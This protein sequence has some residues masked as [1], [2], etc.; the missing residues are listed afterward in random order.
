MERVLKK[1]T[2]MFEEEL[3]EISHLIERSIDSDIS[4]RM[5]SSRIIKA[6]G[7]RLRPILILAYATLLGSPMASRKSEKAILL[8]SAVELIHT[9]TLL[10]D[11]VIDECCVRRGVATANILWGNKYSILV[12][13]YLFSQSF[14]LMV[15]ARS[16][17]SL[18]ILAHTSSVISK[19]ELEQLEMIRN[20]EIPLMSRYLKTAKEKTAELFAAACSVGAILGAKGSGL[21][22][23]ETKIALSAARC[24]G[25]NFGKIFQIVDDFLDYF[26]DESL[27]GKDIRQDLKSRKV[28][29]PL[30]LAYRYADKFEKMGLMESFFGEDDVD[31]LTEIVHSLLAKYQVKDMAMKYVE[32]YASRG[33]ESLEKILSV[34]F[35]SDPGRQRS[36]KFLQVYQLLSDL[37]QTSWIRA[38]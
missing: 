36:Q 1:F 38:R 35:A 14:K 25:L 24:F 9:A 27:L 23:E 26:G 20:K 29:F 7:K 31:S 10:H 33:I 11:D 17:S 28:T 22:R 30:V 18:R 4:V 2:Y 15:S 21:G 6:G 5:A 19:A 37:V 16:L 32:R 13:D 8:A 34:V 12:G 3:L